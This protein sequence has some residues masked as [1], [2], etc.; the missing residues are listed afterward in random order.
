MIGLVDKLRNY[1]KRYVELDA[2]RL[3]INEA[4][5]EIARLRRENQHYREAVGTISAAAKHPSS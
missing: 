5:D 2:D 4:A 1:A 3:L